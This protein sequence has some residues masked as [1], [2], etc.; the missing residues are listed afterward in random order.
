VTFSQLYTA[1]FEDFIKD[2]QRM[3]RMLR[4][5]YLFKCRLNVLLGSKAGWELPVAFSQ[6]LAL[7]AG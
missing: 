4:S 2:R 3:L 6:L 7:K 1:V 5:K